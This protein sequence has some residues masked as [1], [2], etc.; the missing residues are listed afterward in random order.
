M[1][2][3]AARTPVAVDEGMDRLELG[4]GNGCLRNRGETVVIGEG[5]EVLKQ[6]LDVFWWRRDEGRGAR[7]EAAAANPVLHFA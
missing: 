2:E 7:I 3:R 1:D 6:L 5:T 4:M